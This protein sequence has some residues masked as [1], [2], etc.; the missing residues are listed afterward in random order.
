MQMIETGEANVTLAS[1]D[2]VSRVDK[3]VFGRLGPSVRKKPVPG[4]LLR[5]R[6]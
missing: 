2:L 1:P 4:A 5:P 3:I 6:L